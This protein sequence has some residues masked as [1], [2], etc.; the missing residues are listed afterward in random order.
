MINIFTNKIEKLFLGKK[1][2]KKI[3]VA[4]SGGADSLALTLLLKDFCAAKKIELIAA[5]V[6]HKMRQSSSNEALK[7]G[8][9]LAKEKI[10]HKI[11]AIAAKKIPHKN[12]EASLREA[13]YELLYNFCLKEK[14]EFLFLGHHVG[15][16]AE[17]F[18]IRL[19]RGSGLDGLSTLAEVSEYKK[20]KLVRPLL[21]FDKDQLKNFLEEKK[22]KWFEDESNKDE[23]FLR[24]KI[25]NFLETFPEKNLLQARIKSASDEIAKTRDFFDELLLR[26]AKKILK[27]NNKGF[28]FL[29][30]K[31]LQKTEG[32][33]ALKIL[34]LVAM[35]VSQQNYKPRLKELKIFYNY[36]QQSDKIKPR[37]FYGCIFEHSDEKTL[38]ARPQQELEEFYFRTIL[39]N[40]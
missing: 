29:N 27:F 5:T 37:N 26:E 19:F 12:I 8:K 24:N 11:L 34:A 36:L 20:I 39:K 40:V 21:D 4:V 28:C 16:A 23:K 32:K 6:D 13:R 17:N 31:K 30:L 25:R 22:I 9:I 2:P 10:S 35:E 1:L 7:L 3:A 14:I 38:I 33:I 15:D 18:L